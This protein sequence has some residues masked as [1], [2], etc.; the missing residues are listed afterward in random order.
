MANSLI[1]K[2]GKEKPLL[3]KH[4]WIFSGAVHMLP[5]CKNG[6]I[7]PVH[8]FDGLFLGQCYVNKRSSITGRMLSFD[9]GDV[10]QTIKKRIQ[11]AYT[12]RN[13]LFDFSKTNAYRLVNAEG[14]F[15]PGLII[16]RF[17]D[18]LVIQIGTLGMDKLKPFIVKTL[19]ELIQPKC[20]FEKSLMP[21]RK[22]EGLEPLQQVLA[23][24]L[25]NLVQVT[26]N[27]VR[28]LIDILHGQKTGFFLD[29]RGMRELVREHSDGKKVLNCFSY[30]GGFSAYAAAGGALSVDSVDISAGA[31]DLSHQNM[32]LNSITCPAKFIEADVFEFLRHQPMNYDLVVLDPPAFAKRQKDIIPACRGYKDINRI[33][34]HRMPSRSLLLTCSC[35]YYIDEALFQKVIFQA[36][37]E[38]GKKVR[39]ISKHRLAEDH[40]I[41]I[42]HP[43]GDY[44]KSLL[45]YLE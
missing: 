18:H 31:I 24:E 3:N 30:S 21:S 38:A 13:S 8:S 17:N 14:D 7:V 22:D 35:S 43:E 27:G 19:Q 40:P 42:C 29:Q 32:A 39:I 25:S 33:A 45:L 36:A 44:L 11:E 15:L 41:N 20:I 37:V 6:E 1:L 10:Y 12:L 28:F 26:E 4:H 16:D 2:K 34:M 5:D 9:D 23:G